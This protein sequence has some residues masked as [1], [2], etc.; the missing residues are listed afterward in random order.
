MKNTH[1]YIARITLEAITALAI[2]SGDTALLTEAMVQKDHHG[3]PMIQGTSLTGVLRHALEDNA[4]EAEKIIWNTLFGYAEKDQ[5]TGS[6]IKISSAYLLLSDKKIAEGLGSPTKAD[7]E[8]FEH[9]PIRQHVKIGHRGAAEGQ[10]LFSNEVVYKGCQFIFEIELIG[11]KSDVDQWNTLL[12]VLKNPL[13]RLGQGTRNGYGS[14]TIIDD[15]SWERIFDLTDNDNYL[16]YLNF[17]PSF[18][19]PLK[20]FNPI[21][22]QKGKDILSYEL[23]LEPDDSFFFF[24]SGYSDQLADNTPV[25]EE[26]LAYDNH[27]L[28]LTYNNLIPA[29]SIKGA[30]SHRTCY[31]YNRLTETFADQLTPEEYKLVVGENNLAVRTLFGYKAED[32]KG[33]RGIVIID[34]LY[35]SDVNN[36]KIFNHVAIDRFTGGALDGAL[37]SERVSH[38]KEIEIK[39]W[40]EYRPKEPMVLEAFEAALADV[41]NGR[42]PL[43]G[44]TTKGHGIFKGTISPSLKLTSYA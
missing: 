1:R 18:N 17:N 15:N 4:N 40:L 39:I 7:L 11:D 27:G 36:E 13:F 28:K 32:K 22:F 38:R 37:F 12:N 29:S 20:G 33:Q 42:L 44:M 19:A 9:L 16:D 34:D 41:C 26:I 31:H 3:L 23:T 8:I 30:L 10:G 5:G 14:L 24:G 25:L 21:E 43:G 35:Y 2:G 6:K